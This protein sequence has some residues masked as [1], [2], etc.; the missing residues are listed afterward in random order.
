MYAVIRIRGTVNIAPDISKTLELLNLK[1][2]NNL[3]IFQENEQTTKMIKTAQ[4]YAT[5]GKISDTVLKELIEKKA[6][7]LKEGQKVDV[8]KVVE[9][10]KKGKSPKEAGIRNLFKMSPPRR[11]Y[12]RKGIKMPFKLGGAAGNR[13]DKI[14]AL[15]VRM[16]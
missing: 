10:L 14:D 15:V 7:P 6:L 12:E 13:G 5:Y 11:G 4:D 8:K 9:E 3:S 16:M 2:V 1:R